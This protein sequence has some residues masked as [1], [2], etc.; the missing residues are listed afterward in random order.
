MFR[1]AVTLKP[2]AAGLLAAALKLVGGKRG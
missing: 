2:A 1:Q